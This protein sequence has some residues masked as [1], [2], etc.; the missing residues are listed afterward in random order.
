VTWTGT[1]CNCYGGPGNPPQDGGPSP[2]PITDAVLTINGISVDLLAYHNVLYSEW[3]DNDAGNT[4][5]QV[6]T[7]YQSEPFP[8]WSPILP[9]SQYSLNTTFT[10]FHGILSGTG[11]FYLQDSNHSFQT[12]A[13]LTIGVGPIGVP[14]PVTGTGLPAFAL[15][16]VILIYR[17]FTSRRLSSRQPASAAA[18]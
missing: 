15:I 18:A 6:T 3:L 10:P 12:S 7:N 1:D 13:F 8:P 11:V 5:I 14:G 16:A 17:L 2:G 9:S 4:L